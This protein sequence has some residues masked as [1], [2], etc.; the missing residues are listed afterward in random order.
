MQP[1]KKKC[2]GGK[3]S[4]VRLTGLATGNDYSWKLLM[5][6]IGKA[7]QPRYSKNLK[8]LL[9][10]YPGQKNLNGQ[11]FIWG[12]GSWAGQKFWA[13]KLNFDDAVA[14]TVPI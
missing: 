8:R 7:N 11:Q 2:V 5:F 13:S 10:R 14:P 12:V 6:V 4:K 1:R 9:C 3:F